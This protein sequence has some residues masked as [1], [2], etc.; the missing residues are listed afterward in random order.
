[1]SARDAAGDV[2]AAELD[3]HPFFFGTLYQPERSGLDGR[4]HPL[5]AAFVAAAS[6][7]GA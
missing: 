3:G 7:A 1:V 5:I 6:H 4:R 2:R